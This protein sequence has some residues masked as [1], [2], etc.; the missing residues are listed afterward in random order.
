M[1]QAFKGLMLLIINGNNNL[2]TGLTWEK[3]ACLRQDPSYLRTF[4]IPQITTLLI[5]VGVKLKSARY[6]NTQN[7]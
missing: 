5:L 2:K 6:M 4:F 3:I 1:A 7:P